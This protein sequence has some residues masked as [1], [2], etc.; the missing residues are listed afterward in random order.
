V[1]FHSFAVRFYF[2]GMKVIPNNEA[3]LQNKE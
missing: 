1:R 2:I 3:S